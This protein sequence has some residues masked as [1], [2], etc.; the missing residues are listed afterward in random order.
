VLTWDTQHGRVCMHFPSAGSQYRPRPVSL[1]ADAV[2]TVLWTE[3]AGGPEL[4]ARDAARPDREYEPAWTDLAR[5]PAS[6]P[7][8]RHPA[9]SP[10]WRGEVTT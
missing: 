7:R 4:E 10:G 5:I 9:M 8:P 1:D 2:V 6:R 3:D